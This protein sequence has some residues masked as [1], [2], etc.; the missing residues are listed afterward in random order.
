MTT[1]DL[2]AEPTTDLDQLAGRVKALEVDLLFLS[3]KV[4]RAAHHAESAADGMDDLE[5]SITAVDRRVAELAQQA[6]EAAMQQREVALGT[7]PG[8]APTTVDEPRESADAEP[9]KRPTRP[10]LDVLYAWV[11]THIGPLVRKTT[12]TGE[13]GGI[14]WCRSWWNHHDAIERFSALHIVFTELSEQNTL[15]WLSAYLRD[16]LDP[17]LATLTSPVG[18][19]HACTPTKHT[20]IATPLGTAALDLVT[21]NSPEDITSADRAPP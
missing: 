9:A 18:P 12:T 20:D 3:D 16:H 21:G 14:R 1:P 19:F 6:M 13:G 2:P 7:D 11:E 10:D 15:S 8:S 5:D 4:R 17:H